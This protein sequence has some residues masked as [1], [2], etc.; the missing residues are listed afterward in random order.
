M[1]CFYSTGTSSPFGLFYIEDNKSAKNM[2]M[3]KD[4]YICL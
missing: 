1:Y 4:N 3:F 2:L